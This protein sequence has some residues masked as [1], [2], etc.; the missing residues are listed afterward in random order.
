MLHSGHRVIKFRGP[1]RV[2]GSWLRGKDEV[3]L[4]RNVSEK[5]MVGPE[6]LRLHHELL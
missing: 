4:V 6:S 1:Y 5:Y 3:C 2:V